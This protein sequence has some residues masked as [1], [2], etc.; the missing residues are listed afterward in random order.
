MGR[1]SV[2]VIQRVLR[3]GLLTALL[4]SVVAVGSVEARAAG[5]APAADPARVWA[6]MVALSEIGARQ[7]G[8]RASGTPGFA[9][10]EAHAVDA[11]RQAG[12]HVAVEPFTYEA[13]VHAGPAKLAQ[14]SPAPAT[15]VLDADYALT[16]PPPDTDAEAPLALVGITGVP[17]P[18]DGSTACEDGAFDGFPVGAIALV[19]HGSCDPLQVVIAAFVAGAVGVGFISDGTPGEQ[20]PPQVDVGIGFRL[21][22]F[23]LSRA[24]GVSLVEQVRTGGPVT[25][26]FDSGWEM[27]QIASSNVIAER[28]GTDPS[29]V[30]VLGA[31]LDSV[32][33][34]PGVNDNGSGVAALLALAEAWGASGVATGPTL[35]IGL[36][37]SEE[38]GI[39]GSQ[40]YVDNLGAAER[41]A[42]TAYLNFDMLGSRNGY[43]FV[44][45][46][47]TATNPATVSE[48]SAALT[49]RFR[50]YYEAVG[51]PTA[52]I[53]TDGRSDDR[54][55]AVAG[56]P[57]GGLF[58]GAEQSK[59]DAQAIAYG[60]T[61]GVS[62]DVCYH[63]E[64][65]RLSDVNV[66]LLNQLVAGLS[67]VVAELAA[68][69]ATPT[70]TTTLPLLPSTFPG[71]TSPAATPVSAAARFTG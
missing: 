18:A 4:A 35:R 45:D 51:I 9:A 1:M 60:G 48:G 32:L 67:A 66:T 2:G 42:I 15:Y 61:A 41:A 40:A 57:V 63:E 39:L 69:P 12:W 8:N 36:W 3:V 25:L 31:H 70:T 50:A 23:S 5:G 64:C 58:S 62:Y 49:E 44:Y 53:W 6:H 37:G 54:S 20:D 34:G 26:R 14:V 55:F 29:H 7:G 10:S 43:P 17:D 19:V 71:P 24:L 13:P 22:T 56:I 52:G 30:L 59:T 47:A 28:P 46:P 65:D 21:G 68:A 11:L 33:S 16:T 38:L 27:E